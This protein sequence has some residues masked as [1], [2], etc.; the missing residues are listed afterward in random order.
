MVKG[1]IKLAKNKISQTRVDKNFDIIN[2]FILFVISMMFIYPLIFIVSASISDPN[3]V[4]RGEVWLL[5]KNITF[6]GYIGILKNNDIWMG[7][8]NTIFYTIL[9]TLISLFLTVTAAYPLSRKDFAPR[10]IVMA[11]YTFT[12][13]FGGGLI[14]TYLLVKN[15]NLVNTIWVMVIPGAVSIMNIIITRTYFQNSIPSEIQEAA[16]IDGCTNMKF[17]ISIVLPLSKPILAVMT[18]FYA[19]G[20]WNAFFPALIYISKH[21]LQPLQIVL[22]NILLQSQMTADMVSTDPM[23]AAEQ[24]KTSES[25][26]YGVIIVSTLPVLLLY[27]FIQ[28]YFIKGVMIGSIK[29]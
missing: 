24:L 12:M 3:L 8:R 25:I 15:L 19:V 26:K 23:L 7:Y 2:Y 11:I 10:N 18:L 16:E 5:P 29:G 14:P 9:G 1:E 28:K 6:N 20:Q 13:F 4:W 21:D 27:P 22:R 17:L